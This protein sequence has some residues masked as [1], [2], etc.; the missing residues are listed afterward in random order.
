M[1]AI[2]REPELNW[3]DLRHAIELARVGVVG[4]LLRGGTEEQRRTFG[5]ELE[6][7]VKGL[8]D[9]RWWGNRRP[10]RRW[11]SPRSAACPP[12]PGP[13]PC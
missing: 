6:A 4:K 9:E 12:P 3:P 1:S 7:Y 11:R 2:H 5:P 13:R 8:P 10:A